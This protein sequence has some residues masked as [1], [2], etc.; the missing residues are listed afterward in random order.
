M[1]LRSIRIGCKGNAQWMPIAKLLRVTQIEP[2]IPLLEV[3]ETEL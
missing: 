2:R 1:S 3:S